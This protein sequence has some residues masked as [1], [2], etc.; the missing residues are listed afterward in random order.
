MSK[1]RISALIFILK[2]LKKSSLIRIIIIIIIIIIIYVIQITLKNL[3]HTLLLM[4]ELLIL[5][6]LAKY[7]VHSHLYFV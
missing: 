5:C 7:S 4:Q 3:L 6:R 1:R 2:T